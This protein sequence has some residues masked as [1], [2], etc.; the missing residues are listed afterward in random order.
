MEAGSDQG[1]M[2]TILREMAGSLAQL[3]VDVKVL[4]GENQAQSAKLKEL[5]GVKTELEKQKAEIDKL[6]QQPQGKQVVFSASLLADGE[7][8]IGPFPS[9]TPLVFRRVV[10]N[11]GNAYSP[12]TGVFTAPHRGVYHFEWYIAQYGDP[13]H[14]TGVDLMKNTERVFMAWEQNSSGSFGSSSNGV[15]LVLESGDTTYVR[16]WNNTTVFDNTS[17]HTT[18]SGH[19][20]FPL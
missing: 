6:K 11:I 2:Y 17:H 3:K 10:T 7:N 14:P 16:L 15:N 8:T 1:D 13:R 5:D 9:H 19:L 12:N 20:L 18:F 4:Q